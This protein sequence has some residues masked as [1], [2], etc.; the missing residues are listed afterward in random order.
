M[1][2][3]VHGDNEASVREYPS[4]LEDDQQKIVRL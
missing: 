2:R 4:L 1:R 3:P